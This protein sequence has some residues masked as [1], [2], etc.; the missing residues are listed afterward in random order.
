MS[1]GTTRKEFGEKTMNFHSMRMVKQSDCLS[2]ILFKMTQKVC[3]AD[4][5][6]QV[7]FQIGARTLNLL[8]YVE[9]TILVAEAETG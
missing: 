2:P 4:F 1:R 8:T 9:D 5:S 7:G 6:E 3:F